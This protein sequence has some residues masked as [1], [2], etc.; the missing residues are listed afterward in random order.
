MGIFKVVAA[1]FIAGVMAVS[2]MAADAPKPAQTDTKEASV[3]RQNVIGKVAV[4]KSGKEV[5]V[6]TDRDGML[7]VQEKDKGAFKVYDGK[8]VRV[9]CIV[10]P[11]NKLIPEKVLE[12]MPSN[13]KKK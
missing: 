1:L 11:D 2:L 8:D 10:G 5:T 4:S 12:V 3:K 9:V 13:A 7:L 6:I